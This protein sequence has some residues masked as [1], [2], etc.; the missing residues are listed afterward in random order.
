MGNGDV[1]NVAVALSAE[2]KTQEIAYIQKHCV[3]QQ[4]V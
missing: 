1:F 2:T 3:P 4:L